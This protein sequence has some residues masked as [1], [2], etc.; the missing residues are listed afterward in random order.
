[1]RTKK[2]TV[3]QKKNRNSQKSVKSVKTYRP[4]V[5]IS[6]FVAHNNKFSQLILRKITKI[7]AE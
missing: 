3:E 1:M 7:V 2:K 5:A 4:S 6:A